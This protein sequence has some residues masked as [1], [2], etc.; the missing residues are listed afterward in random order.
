MLKHK[1]LNQ[2]KPT[3][4]ANIGNLITLINHPLEL[5]NKYDI[6]HCHSGKLTFKNIIS[7]HVTVTVRSSQLLFFTLIQIHKQINTLRIISY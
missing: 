2:P 6:W 4:H 7:F 1:Y 3:Q 5:S